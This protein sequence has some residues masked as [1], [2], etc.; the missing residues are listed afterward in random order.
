VGFPVT[1][2]IEYYLAKTKAFQYMRST[3]CI[4]VAVTR[5]IEFLVTRRVEQYLAKTKLFSY[6]FFMLLDAQSV[7]LLDTL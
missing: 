6:L 7:L 2:R 3:R 1:R 4:K 5:R